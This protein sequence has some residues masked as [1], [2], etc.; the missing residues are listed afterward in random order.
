VF[1]GVL[2]AIFTFVLRCADDTY[3]A[4]AL[5]GKLTPQ[6]AVAHWPAAFVRRRGA[7]DLNRF[8]PP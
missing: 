6:T 1:R 3:P 2:S 5:L 4:L 8:H 7:R